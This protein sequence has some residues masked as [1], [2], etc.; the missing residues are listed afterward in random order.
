MP[1]VPSCKSMFSICKNKADKITTLG[2]PLD[3]ICTQPNIPLKLTIFKSK[4]IR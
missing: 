2:K 4:E 3:P 1:Q